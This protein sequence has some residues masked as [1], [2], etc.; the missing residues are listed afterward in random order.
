M[1]VK[2]VVF[3]R[4]NFYSIRYCMS[5]NAL[6]YGPIK[7]DRTTNCKGFHLCKMVLKIRMTAK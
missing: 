6:Q 1:I 2:E 5:F 7:N 4:G 3:T